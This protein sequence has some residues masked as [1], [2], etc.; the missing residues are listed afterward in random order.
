MGRDDDIRLRYQTLEFG[1]NDIHVRTLRDVQQFEDA[2]GEAE[3]LGIGSAAW[4]MFGVVWTSGEV[5]ARFMFE[6]EVEGRRI[7]EVGCGIALASLVLNRRGADITA[8]DHHPR[9]GEFLRHNVALNGDPP[10][11]FV[12]SGW[13]DAQTE[14][15]RFDLI[16]GSDLLYEGAHVELVAAFIERHATRRCSVVI[17][18]PGRHN[19]PRFSKAMVR[20]GYSHVQTRAPAEGLATGDFHGWI[21]EYDRP[22]P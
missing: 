13:V 4:P 9:A 17:V 14:L 18:D 21:I 22:G 10:V 16:V 8:T 2:G 1:D 7:L 3:R 6:Y 12:R 15:G 20:R 5:L 11:P 19:H